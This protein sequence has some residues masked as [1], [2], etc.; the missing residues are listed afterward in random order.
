MGERYDV[1]IVGAGPAGIFAAL[2]LKKLDG[3]RVLMLEKGPDL[4][5]RRCYAREGRCRRCPTCAITSGWGGAGAFSDGKLSLSPEVGGW[6]GEYVGEEELVRLIERVDELYL[7]F[8][9]STRVYGGDEE[10][11]DFWRRK[12]V[13]S[14]LILTPCRF[15]HLGTD[16]SQMVLGAI[17]DYLGDGVVARTG[18]EVKEVM[19][20]EGRVRGVRLVGGEEFQ[21][22]FV[23]LAPG[24]EGAD[25]LAG[26][27]RRLGIPMRTNVVDIGLR[28]E[29]PAPVLEPITQ[30]LY[31]PKIHYFSRS[32]E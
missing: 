16:R 20:D 10:R 17:R 13:Q 22:D 24:R 9:A 15:R 25:W 29:V 12:A 18:A 30:D 21:A 27:M 23:V 26:E 14:D 3:I 19:V 31:E 1:I 7:E 28:V 5:Q 6:L 8:G 2:E 32:F 4:G 11:I